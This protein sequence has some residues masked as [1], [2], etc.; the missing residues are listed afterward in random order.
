M[1]RTGLRSIRRTVPMLDMVMLW[2]MIPIE[3]RSSS[4]EGF[5][6]NWETPTYYNDTWEYNG[7]NWAKINTAH[8][9]SGRWV[10]FMTYDSNRQRCVLF[11]GEKQ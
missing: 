9:P 5:N 7:S 6:G 10:T 8:A 1:E 11:G 3:K 2:F 4:L